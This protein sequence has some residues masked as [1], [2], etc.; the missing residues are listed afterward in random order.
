MA[1]ESRFSAEVSDRAGGGWTPGDH[2]RAEIDRLGLDQI[3]VSQ[4]TGVSRQSINNII[5]GRQPISRAMAAKLGRLTGQSS[6]YWLRAE[7][8]RPGT[9][10]A[11]S[12]VEST[13]RPLGVGILVNHQIV[14]AI[15]DGVIAIEP[16]IETNVQPASIDLTLDDFIRTTHGDD[17]DITEN[18]SF[19]VKAGETV[20]VRTREW[21]G[22]PVNYVGRVGGMTKLAKF[23]IMVSHGFQIDP[24]YEGHL[25]FC[26][27]N[28]GAQ[29]FVLRAGDPIISLEIMPLNA[30]PI[31]DERTTRQLREAGK[32]VSIV[33]KDAYDRLIRD[34]IR[35]RV[36]V[37]MKGSGAEARI[38]ELTIGFEAASTED[39]LDAA[40]AGALMGLR[41][42]RDHST[43]PQDEREKYTDF[44]SAIAADIRL[45][46]DE[47][48]KAVSCL[49]MAFA[50][51]DPAL[52]VVTLHD[53]KR[54][55][56]PLPSQTS[57]ISLQQLGKQLRQDAGELILTLTGLR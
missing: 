15:T 57:A 51:S 3:E 55:I 21:V 11:T 43:M 35:A 38:D 33:R 2:L 30:T 19:E 25:Q 17:I 49:N 22:F 6:D 27:F 12:T 52:L 31:L 1:V 16:F 39:A 24:G 34:A 29:T 44:F 47:V 32:V 42:L 13:G 50:N 36:R 48:R 18:Q 23:G 37:E 9:M 45:N 56:L 20:M 26:I 14:R 7:F 41:M 46:A 4:V 53:G 40:V 5:N 8:P 10:R 54:A 28:A